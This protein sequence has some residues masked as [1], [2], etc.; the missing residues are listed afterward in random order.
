MAAID[1]DVAILGGGC[2]GL[3]LAVRLA[4]SGVRV[5]VIEPRLEYEDDRVWSFFRTRPDP[6]TACVRASWS[7]WHVSSGGVTVPRRS[8]RLRYESVSSGA[9]Y[10]LALQI[11]H[12]APNI[13]LRLGTSVLVDPRLPAMHGPWRMETSA[14]Q[15]TSR[16]V[17]DTR[18]TGRTSGY[19]QSFLGQEIRVGF[20][21]FDPEDVPMM[22]F[23]APRP[24]RVDFLYI[25]PFARNEALV[26][27]T[28]FGAE[29]PD[30]SEHRRW[31]EC[32]IAQLARGQS[33]DILREERAFIPMVLP[34][35]GAP[36]APA[37]FAHAGL[38]G[39]AARPSTGYAYQRIQQMADLCTAQILRGV[40]GIDL[41]LDSPVTRFMDGVFL[42]VLQRRPDRGPAL[43]SALFRNAPADRLER[44]LSGSTAPIDRVSVMASLPPAPFLREVFTG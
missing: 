41:R 9:F 10:Q 32:E 33:Y 14:G 11:C 17:I 20:D 31:L 21:A 37:R 8:D 44:F 16:Y 38:R 39:G 36:I 43:F 24:D 22:C 7:K 28:T 40:D 19:G 35:S 26:E 15:L 18:P 12:A 5:T 27:V 4:G 1:A 23:A 29:I 42:R 30:I 6:F 13:D 25:L 34:Q 3:S 2:A